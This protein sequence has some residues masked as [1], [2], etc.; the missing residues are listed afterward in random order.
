MKKT[1]R[2]LSLVLTVVIAVSTFFTV[3]TVS[4]AAVPNAEVAA[5]G[6][7][8]ANS[9][10]TVQVVDD[11]SGSGEKVLKLVKSYSARKSYAIAHNGG[12]YE[13]LNGHTY[14]IKFDVRTAG[15]TGVTAG[16]TTGGI[17]LYRATATGGAG[18]GNKT[19]IRGMSKNFT[20]TD[21]WTT[22]E[23]E[24]TANL[25]TEPEQ[26]YLLLTYY[27]SSGC[28]SLLV[29]NISVSEK[30]SLDA[31]N[32]NG[33]FEY[34][35]D[36]LGSGVA[37]TKLATEATNRRS[38]AIAKDGV[39][40][41]LQHGHTYKLK[42]EACYY[43]EAEGMYSADFEI[44][45][46]TPTGGTGNGNKSAISG[47][48]K[49]VY[50]AKDWQYFEIEFTADLS[51]NPEYKY[52][53]LTKYT[54]DADSTMYIR[55][56]SVEDLF[57]F[58]PSNTNPIAK[59]EMVADPVKSGEF[60]T[61][62]AV[63]KGSRIC[64]GMAQKGDL[65]TLQDGHWYTMTFDVY[66]NGGTSTS[67]E[68]YRSTETGGQGSGNKTP[69]SSTA[70]TVY[71]SSSWQS[72]EISFSVDLTDNPEYMYLLFS[73]YTSDTSSTLLVKNVV[74]KDN[75]GINAANSNGT[76]EA[77][78]D[79]LVSGGKAVKLQ[80]DKGGR[81][82]FAV[83][84]NGGTYALA[85]KHTY[86]LTLDVLYINKGTASLSCDMS[87]YRATETGGSGNGNKTSFGA[88]LSI[89]T[90]S[91]GKWQ[92]VTTEFTADL[93]INQSYRYLLLTS[94]V[95][96]SDIEVY[97]KNIKIEDLSA[98]KKSVSGLSLAG[99]QTPE[100]YVGDEVVG[101]SVTVNYKDGTKETID[102]NYIVYAD[103]SKAG[104]SKAVISYGYASVA[105]DIN[106]K[107]VK[108][109]LSKTSLTLAK[110]DSYKLTAS[111]EPA[112]LPIIWTS[113][114]TAVA[115]VTP[116][117]TVKAI[118]A[119]TARIA[120]V[121]LAGANRYESICTVTVTETTVGSS[122]PQ[123]EMKNSEL[124]D[125]GK[126][127]VTVSL[128]NASALKTLGIS[129]IRYDTSNLKMLSAKWLVDGALVSTW[130]DTNAK[131]AVMFTGN[132]NINGD[133]LQFTFQMKEYCQPEISCD[134][135]AKQEV[136]GNDTAYT[137][138]ATPCTL[139]SAQIIGDVNGNM[140]VDS[141][142]A[143]YLLYS[144]L[145]E[146]DYPR[147]QNCDFNGSGVVDSDDATYLLYYTLFPKSYPLPGKND[148][149]GDVST[150]E[151]T[152]DKDQGFGEWI[153][154]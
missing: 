115:E 37:V 19:S 140:I 25:T 151:G 58:A 142:D 3:A 83:A 50:S 131:G 54:V 124:S 24:F 70:Q 77:V 139:S 7:N 146:E 126:F 36:P 123:I 113:Y 82:S 91:T 29:K 125:D 152:E 44:Y 23:L 67:L 21:E 98:P 154:F 108:V 119:G 137:I 9:N 56:L 11:P 129:N 75:F 153:P 4:S 10:G 101:L 147:Y 112:K 35:T 30:Y 74:V 8:T 89:N 144:T 114:D 16:N 33:S 46:T 99:T 38:Y 86:R 49:Y 81:Y 26:K 5:L 104:V 141:D 27:F 103:T 143:V 127:L 130:D 61:N 59:L 45:R 43:P 72:K 102:S 2:M 1:T 78:A 95:T 90:R 106:I 42:F 52:L 62:L 71:A 40:Y 55:N 122:D 47:T 84:D 64:Y 13:L 120:G 94:Y 87:L 105:V 57:V 51:S 96:T 69:I 117:G 53:L 132:T 15:D 12:S 110:G 20:I 79:P 68:L 138:A 41:E 80:S 121:T 111:T 134:V 100:C 14:I 85:H 6:I 136:N 66:Y 17:L 31:S 149:F 65:Y 18:N 63:T 109:F 145:Y 150:D 60:A 116:D 118:S 22:I 88:P 97:V 148:S 93:S 48:K 135:T 92:T 133:I 73:A 76:A 107:P 128:K 32:S 34:V 28:D 39:A